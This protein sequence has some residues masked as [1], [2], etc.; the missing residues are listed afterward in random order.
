MVDLGLKLV[1]TAGTHRVLGEA[2]VRSTRLSKLAEGRPNIADLI[3]NSQVHL[4]INTPTRKGYSTDE[5]KIRSLAVC[6]NI[7]LTTT[8]TGA[9]AAVQAVAAL[10]ADHKPDAAADDAWT[11]RALQ[12]YFPT[13]KP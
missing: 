9:Q 4:L 12:D 1:A 10:K 3:A 11:V 7:P 6:H 5:G 13:P 8:V 2:G